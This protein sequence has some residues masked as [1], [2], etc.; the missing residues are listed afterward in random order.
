MG[1]DSRESVMISNH[2]TTD[3][4]IFL[5]VKDG[6]LAQ[7]TYENHNGIKQQLQL[8]ILATCPGDAMKRQ[9][10]E[11]MYIYDQKPELNTKDE[12]GNANVSRPKS[13]DQ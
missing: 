12:W 1:V 13:R 5:K 2:R 11:A 7:H 8:Q 9:V 3:R 10:T 6:P 4:A